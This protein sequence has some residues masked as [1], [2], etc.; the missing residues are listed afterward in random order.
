MKRYCVFALLILL[1]AFGACDRDK[2]NSAKLAEVNGQSLSLEGFKATF[3]VED[4]E[5]LP[6]DLR[7]RYV[8][9]WVNLTLLAQEAKNLKLDKDLALKQRLEYAQKKV[10]ANALIAQSLSEINI[11]EDQLF[12]YFRIHQSDFQKP[13]KLYHIERIRLR[14]KIS[15]EN[16]LQQLNGGMNFYSALQQYSQENLKAQRGSIGFVE[17]AS[18]DSVFWQKAQNMQLNECG[19]VNKDGDWY[20]FR[21]T[22][23]KD[24]EAV[25]N[26]EEQRS[27]IRRRIILEKQEE[28]YQNLLKSIK[29]RQQNIYYY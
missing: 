20:V 2:D 17:P 4:W 15:A 18:A 27:E 1:F 22:E 12:S 19:I 8:E 24:G 3:G 23:E 6:P 11:T 16:L 25:A 7:K 13:V 29:A 26:F 14:D 28:V 5:A 9:D 10:L 21:Y